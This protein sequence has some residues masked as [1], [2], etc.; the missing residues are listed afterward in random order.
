MM[1]YIDSS[2][3]DG[4]SVPSGHIGN[5]RYYDVLV[6]QFL[7]KYEDLKERSNADPIDVEQVAG[8]DILEDQEMLKRIAERLNLKPEGIVVVATAVKK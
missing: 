2:G 4:L 5:P 8:S 3:G 1:P 7:R 6:H